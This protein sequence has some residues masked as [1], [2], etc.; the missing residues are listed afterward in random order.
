M[1]KAVTD[2][3][4]L[5]PPPFVQGLNVWSSGDGTSGSDTYLGD[6]NA[7]LVAADQDFGGCLELVKTETV[8][9]LRYMGETPLLPGCYLQVKV[10]L[11][12]LSGNFPSVRIAAWAGGAG[13]SNVS[14]VPETGPSVALS[15]YGEVVEVSAIVGT[16][17]RS[18]V[19][20]PWG[21]AAFY[22][23][24]G[25]DLTGASGG[26][27][28]IDDIEIKDVTS[29]F[30]RDMVDVVD[31]LDF[32][33]LGDGTSDDSVAFQAANNASDGR[34]VLVPEGE[35][36]L[37]D[38]I[39]FDVP[40]TFVGTV[41]MPDDKMLILTKDFDL[42][43]YI[44]AFGDEETAFKKAFQALLNNS[45]H[46]SL[47]MGGRRVTVNAP[48][49][50]QAAVPNKTSYAT[51]RV[52][53]NGQLSAANS[54]AWDTETVTSQATY[55][56]SDSRTLTDVANVANIPVGALVEGNGVGREIYVASKNVGAGE[57]TL[58]AA[59][60][61]AVG[62]QSY[63]FHDFKYMLDFSGFQQLSKFEINEVEVR[64]SGHCSG[65][66]LAPSGSTFSMSGC[67]INR[68]KDRGVTSIDSGCQ[69]ML[70]DRCQFL[71]DEDA[72]DVEDRVSIALNANSNDVK[73][74]SNRATRFR[75]F[76]VMGGD[77]HIIVANHF[78]QGDSVPNGVRSAGIVLADNYSS[79]T[80]SANYIDNCFLEWTNERDVEPDYVSGFSFASLTFTDNICLCGDTADWFSYLIVK[81]YG[82]GHFLN[83]VTV[84]GNKFRS[85]N[86]TIDR[87]E[88]VDNS[89]APIDHSR[90]KNVTFDGNTYHQ[91]SAQ[92]GN[93]CRVRHAEAT[94]SKTW[95]VDLGNQIP[96]EAEARRVDA[97]VPEGSIK[98][99]SND[100]IHTMP[101][102]RTLQGSQK[103][104]VD[105]VWE[106]AVVGEVALIVRLDE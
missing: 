70:I 91:V 41:S 59:L 46:E 93:P 103:N 20:M 5:M 21:V 47:D 75:H 40:V 37:E 66:R 17:A 98:N 44:S 31:V 45:D 30:L 80:I 60:Y 58:S 16:G 48:I 13:G 56:S 10:R 51:R 15:T 76:A 85:I 84:T 23:H 94:V 25:I 39:T 7:A 18:G 26:I 43:N 92:V 72:L 71:S 104:K 78:F 24:F 100:T 63:T 90:N 62:T 74:R 42:P 29:F 88:R 69:G 57:I 64:C 81:P 102:I 65:I 35:Y 38:S 86:G 101:F 95:V 68:P 106:E 34:R 97:I 36:R 50:M 12:A 61:N 105:L 28:R 33:A 1:N 4:T 19:D 67:V 54:A 53:R 49:D 77:N 8:Q 96:F 83:G 87:A 89:F 55:D 11:K 27:V 79:S 52:I 9:R 3:V 82:S 99:A 6:P 73:L 2:G 14:G 32:G 22:G